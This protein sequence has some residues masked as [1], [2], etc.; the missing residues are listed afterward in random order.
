MGRAM[1]KKRL[2]LRA[3]PTLLTGV[4][5]A[6]WSDG[7]LLLSVESGGAR[8]TLALGPNTALQLLQAIS[9]AARDNAAPFNRTAAVLRKSIKEEA[10]P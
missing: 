9:G 10:K 2:K 1:S 4:G 8:G 7:V 5:A 3:D 6:E